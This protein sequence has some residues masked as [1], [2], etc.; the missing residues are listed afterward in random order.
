MKTIYR[1]AVAAQFTDLQAYCC[2]T[3]L[4]CHCCSHW[5]ICQFFVG[6]RSFPSLPFP[7]SLPAHSFLSSPPCPSPVSPPRNPA[8]GS[9]ERCKLP[10]RGPGQSSGRC[11]ISAPFQLKMIASERG[12]SNLVNPQSPD[13][14]SPGCSA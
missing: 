13:K 2:K 1:A 10:Q 5:W 6:G 8:R 7:L 11:S 12:Y 9:E 3:C 4:Q 14:S